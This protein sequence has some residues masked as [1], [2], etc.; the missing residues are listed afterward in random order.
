MV[1][2]GFKIIFLIFFLVFVMPVSSLA[3]TCGNEIC[4]NGENCLNCPSDCCPECQEFITSLPYNITQ[5]DTYYCLTTSFANLTETAVRF[6]ESVKNSTLDCLGNKIIGNYSFPPYGIYLSENTTNNT[7][8]NCYISRFIY[9]VYLNET[10]SNVVFNSTV[11]LNYYGIYLF[12]SHNNTFYFN[13]IEGNDIGILLSTSSETNEIFNN[14]FNNTLNI[15]FWGEIHSNYWNTTKQEGERIYSPGKKIGGNYWS[16]PNTTGFSDTCED[17]DFD[18]FCDSSYI[19]DPEHTGNNTDYFPL[20]NKYIPCDEYINSL[21]YNITQNNTYYCLNTSFTDS[22]TIFIQFGNSSLAV[23]NSTLDCLWKRLE[24]I[25]PYYGIHLW[26]NA[27]NNKVKNCYLVNLSYG[28][29]IHGPNNTIENNEINTCTV[30]IF[31]N[32]SGNVIRKNT[33]VNSSSAAIELSNH[34]FNSLEKN[35]IFFHHYGILL[36]SESNDLIQNNLLSFNDYTIFIEANSENNTI[37]NNTIT[38]NNVVVAIYKY[39]T[40]GNSIT[41]NLICYNNHSLVNVISLGP[42]E[43]DSSWVMDNNT[44]CVELIF[45]ANNTLYSSIKYFEFNISNYF[46]SF[47]F[48]NLSAVASCYLFI[49]N[50][51]KA[52]NYTVYN[53]QLS[54]I[55]LS[56]TQPGFYSWYVYCNDSSGTNWGN[57]SVQYFGISYPSPPPIPTPAPPP[58]IYSLNISGLPS[59]VEMNQSETKTVCFT[60]KNNGNVELNNISI[61][62]FG[63]PAE[64]YLISPNFIQKLKVSEN[65]TI[66]I[67]FIIPKDAESKLYQ[68]KI[69]ATDTAKV[70]TNT[71]LKVLEKILTCPPCPPPTDWSDCVLFKQTRKFYN[72]SS[73]TNYTCQEFI[74]E[75]YCIPYIQPEKG[76]EPTYI[77]II[78]LV[79]VVIIFVIFKF[80]R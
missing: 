63:I 37:S 68:I 36:E 35:N 3:Q 62:L 45:P 55:Y 2:N 64:W 48:T 23:E 7:I 44:F 59:L 43:Y 73:E 22:T 28:I 13:R 54:T 74:E 5:N 70:Q 52:A 31:I 49:N 71:T 16:H 80:K 17:S 61:F 4:E 76:V 26:N 50:E 25:P 18:G 8:K 66:C 38:Y 58:V 79:I 27:K 20:S 15:E 77:I 39:N 21:P 46:R 51:F 29:V 19:L 24:G 40:F 11:I 72:C 65:I 14:L 33:I 75:R 60:L 78:G 42:N 41:N 67:A 69:N 10:N 1:R 9:G 30:G 47:N 34:S 56:I 32:S 12:E 53:N 6:E 57:S